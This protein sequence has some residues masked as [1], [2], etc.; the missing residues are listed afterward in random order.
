ML[1]TRR[2]PRAPRAA[3]LTLLVASAF[4]AG[5]VFS[6]PLAA[7][8][9]NP[10]QKPGIFTKGL[11]YIQTHYVEDVQETELLYGAPRGLTHLLDPHSRFMDPQE[12]GPLQQETGGNEESHRI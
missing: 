3:V 10:Y 8:R 5:M 11:S 12:D 9:F 6:R 7:G 4:G 2:F 1:P